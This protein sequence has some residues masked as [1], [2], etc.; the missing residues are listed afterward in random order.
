MTESNSPFRS[1]SSTH[2]TPPGKPF[3]RQ[4]HGKP[5]AHMY[6]SRFKPTEGRSSPE[7]T[8]RLGSQELGAVALGS[9]RTAAGEG[10][11]TAVELERI[12]A[13]ELGEA[14]PVVGATASTGQCRGTTRPRMPSCSVTE[15]SM[16]RTAHSP[17]PLMLMVTVTVT[18]TV[19]SPGAGGS[20]LR[21]PGQFGCGG[22]VTAHGDPRQ[23]RVVRRGQRLLRELS[24]CGPTFPRREPLRGTARSRAGSAART[25]DARS[26]CAAAR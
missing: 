16:R 2:G 23:C 1:R 4:A 9:A 15:S 3:A 21:L 26:G 10:L 14:L 20:H 11:L 12:A 5:S 7:L 24:G 19:Y 8:A 6:R 22:R 18:V 13:A 25:P 17:G